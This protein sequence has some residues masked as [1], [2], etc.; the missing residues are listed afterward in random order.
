M[1]GHGGRLVGTGAVCEGGWAVNLSS[2]WACLCCTGGSSSLLLLHTGLYTL[3]SWLTG[4][5]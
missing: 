3:L 4:L 1:L 5:C 2:L